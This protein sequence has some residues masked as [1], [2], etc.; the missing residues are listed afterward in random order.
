MKK[1][2]YVITRANSLVEYFT[3]STSYDNP[4]WVSLDEATV[5]ASGEGASAAAKKLWMYG[6]Y[7]AMVRPVSEAIDLEMEMPPEDGQRR[8]V[9]GMD[10]MDGMGD[11]EGGEEGMD[12][13]GD[14]DSTDGDMVA[15][16]QGDD[17]EDDLKG[18]CPECDCDPCECDDAVLVDGQPTDEIPTDDLDDLDSIEGEM[19]EPDGNLDDKEQNEETLLGQHLRGQAEGEETARLH[20]EEL[21]LLGKKRHDMKEAEAFYRNN[22]NAI[23]KSAGLEPIK[24][25]QF[26]MPTRPGNDPAPPAENDTTAATMTDPKSKQINFN[27]PVGTEDKP[28]TDL[29]YSGAMEH[30]EK[31]IVPAEVMSELKAAVVSFDNAAKQFDRVDDVKG[32]YAMTAASALQQLVDDLELGTVAGIKQAQIHMSSYMN[33]ISAHVPSEV[34]NFIHRGGRKS[35]LRDM[36]STKWDNVRK[37]NYTPS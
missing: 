15:A 7:G 11:M 37:L 21:R 22:L 35:S 6:S 18:S 16:K 33:I 3:A 4:T 12:E 34:V 9:Q 36:F 14:E 8:D 2:G 30:D 25:A 27:D 10:G 1:Q 31:V 19:G 24:E 13:I 26:K 28:Q 5:Y 29:T 17:L 32:S 23:R 20:P